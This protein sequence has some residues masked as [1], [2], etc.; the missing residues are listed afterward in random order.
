MSNLVR[1]VCMEKLELRRS[2]STLGVAL[3]A[4]LL[5]GG[6]HGSAPAHGAN[7][8]PP[9][10]L[11]RSFAT[12]P[13]ANAPAPAVRQANSPAAPTPPR[14]ERPAGKTWAADPDQPLRAHSPWAGVLAVARRFA[15]TDTQYESG[16]PSQAVRQAIEATSAPRLARELLA[17]PP[18]PPPGTTRV[19]ERVRAVT[20]LGQ[21]ANGAQVLVSLTRKL[22]RTSTPG[23][24]ELTL[25]RQRGRWLVDH[26]SVLS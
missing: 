10:P 22:R 1:L 13:A 25:A 15:A 2:R 11:G 5:A 4:A 21:L 26:L 16:H 20:P 24:L 8:L 12:A 7:A 6:C 14:P 18:A 19:D 3:T 9:N 17:R 23:S